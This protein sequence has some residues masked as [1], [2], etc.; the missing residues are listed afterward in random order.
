[1]QC[2]LER[3]CGAAFEG[4]YSLSELKKLRAP[5]LLHALR[6][7]QG[8]ALWLLAAEGEQ[9]PFLPMLKLL[10][11]VSAARELRVVDPQGVWR[12]A[13]RPGIW[14]REPLRLARESVRGLLAL[15][16]VRREARRLLGLPRQAAARVAERPRVAYLKT[17]LWHGVQAGGSIA[18]VAGVVNGFARRGCDINVYTAETL[19][20][21]DP[22]VPVTYVSAEGAFS[23]PPETARYV[24]HESFVEQARS[25]LRNERPELLYQRYCLANYVGVILAREWGIPLVLEYN[26]SEVWASENWG[27]PLTFARTA[28]RIEELNLRHAH[29]IV[30]VSDALRD[31]LRARGIGD[32]RIVCQPNGVDPLLFDPDRFRGTDRLALRRALGLPEDA[33]VCLFLGTFGPWHGVDVLAQ[34]I[35]RL[36]TTRSAWLDEQRCC[37]V[38]VGDG[39][40]MPRVRATLSQVPER[41]YR[42]AGLVPQ[43]EAPRHIAAADLL[44]SP[45]V[46][47][48]DGSRF[49]GSPTKLFEYMAMGKAIIASELEQI[50]E[51]LYGSHHFG[52]EGIPADDADRTDGCAVLTTPGSVEELIAAL[53]Y[54]VPRPGV[55]ERLGAA[56]RQRVLAN[57]TWER[58]VDAILGRV[59][60]LAGSGP[61]PGA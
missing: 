53:E 25:V 26:G 12:T 48:P 32:E 9:Q 6:A 44:L 34:A 41:F 60:A 15:G 61:L 57:Y 55:R 24:F 36:A 5:A 23:L 29:L 3:R 39:Q 10:G 42:L 2:E 33:V 20:L 18:H 13:H 11:A 50:G 51:V 14:I 8:D 35:R 19:P 52:R 40:M 1:L 46:P 45:H 47:N 17:N 37:F 56:A 4:C 38:F 28:R 58:H 30:V 54:L 16:R 7:M 27:F 22:S 31:E 49:F 21:I 43:A 59:Y